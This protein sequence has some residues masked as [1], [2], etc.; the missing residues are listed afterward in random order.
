MNLQD[1]LKVFLDDNDEYIATLANEIEVI[2]MDYRNGAID[3]DMHKEL[4]ADVM[5]LAETKEYADMLE[6]K[7]KVEKLIDFLKVVAKVL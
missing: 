1:G 5:E 4:I 6:T 2:H 3:E 7:I